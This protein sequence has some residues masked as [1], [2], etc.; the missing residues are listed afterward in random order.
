MN[1]YYYLARGKPILLGLISTAV[2]AALFLWAALGIAQAAP[3]L[4]SIDTATDAETATIT[5]ET[6]EPSTAQIHYGTTT[7]YGTFSELN[8][9]EETS[10][11]ITLT[12]LDPDTLYN[13]QILSADDTGT[14]TSENQT[15]TTDQDG[16]GEG[17]GPMISN[18]EATTT[19][20]SATITWDTDEPALSQ[21]QFGLSESDLENESLTLFTASETFDH[22]VELSGLESDTT[23]FYRAVS[24]DGDDNTTLSDIESFTTLSG[25][26]EPSTLD[27]LINALERLMGAFPAFQSQIQDF[28]DQL[29]DD[30]NGDGDGNGDGNGNGDGDGD[31]NGDGD[32]DNGTAS[33]DQDGMT[34]QAGT[35]IDFAGRGFGPEEQ[36]RITLDGD[37]I[38]TGFTNLAGSFTSG[39]LSVPDEPGTYTYT[40]VGQETGRTATAT[41]TLVE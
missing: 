4:S 7:S 35:G 41:L 8:D 28:I 19:Q 23:Y 20:S 10:H 29:Q 21:V 30:D 1:T 12:D 17:D 18:L 16:D 40:F 33:V 22:S 32:G 14:T 34:V 39:S 13:F 24:T 38:G 9:D 36:V 2:A 15:F 3:I 31:G 26:D 37:L 11:S 25:D 6:D 5:W 27:R